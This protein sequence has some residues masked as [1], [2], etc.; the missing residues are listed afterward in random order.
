M[1]DYHE[2]YQSA[3]SWRYGSPA[4]RRLWSEAHRRRLMRRV[5]L[6]LA[7]AQHAAG[8]VA[9]DQLAELRRTAEAIDIDRAGEIEAVTHH[10]VMAELRAWAEQAPRGGAILHLGAT[11]ADI[12]DNVDALRLRHG[13]QLLREPLTGTIA[14]LADRVDE[15]ADLVTL[16]WTHL[17]PAAPTTVGYRLASSLQDFLHDLELLDFVSH[18]LTGKGFKGAVGTSAS[19]AALVEDRGLTPAELEADAMRRLGLRAA[20]V[21]TQVYPRKTDWLV[22]TVLAGSAATAAR[23]AFNLR[24]LQSPPFGEW[25]EPFA[26]DQVGSTAMPWKRNPISAENVCSLA[27]LV[28]MLPAV[29]WQ[30][31]ANSLLERTLDDSANRRTLL[32]EAFLASDEILQRTRRLAAHLVIDGA[33]IGR[34]IERYGPFAAV[35]RLLVLGAAAGGDRQELHERLRQHSMA[36]W[37]A[38]SEGLPNPLVALVSEDELIRRY[39]PASTIEALLAHPEAYV[40]DAPQRARAMA[41]TARTTLRQAGVLTP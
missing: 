3:F 34:T 28:A 16:G 8:I 23:F 17:Q 31:E 19:Y 32:P 18:R 7:E 6:A 39:L 12:T 9:D 14:A 26:R 30:N 1:S 35:E 37:Q 4:M 41:A 38:V 33:A 24:L 22:L 21:T 10:D 40:G 13:L 20:T 36:A 2:T 15:T 27:R 11:S 5:W 29:A 25:S